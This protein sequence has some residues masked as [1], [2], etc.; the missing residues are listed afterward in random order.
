MKDIKEKDKPYPSEKRA[1]VMNRHFTEENYKR[2]M[3]I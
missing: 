2:P 1:K 3:K